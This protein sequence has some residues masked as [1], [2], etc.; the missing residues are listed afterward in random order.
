LLKKLS[1]LILSSIVIFSYCSA[2]SAKTTFTNVAKA[3][4]LR[5]VRRSSS[6]APVWGDYDNDG[7][8]DIYVAH[9]N[10]AGWTMEG[11]VFFRNNGD[12]T[13]TDVTEEAGLDKNTGDNDHAG[14]LDY[15]NDGNLDLY[16]YNSTDV[17]DRIA[18][19][20]N[21]GD[22]TFTDVTEEA[23][24]G[25]EPGH[26]WSATFSDYNNDGHLDIYVTRVWNNPNIFFESNGDGTFTDQTD[27]AGIG[28]SSSCVNVISG[29]Y[30]NDG[31]MDIYLA[32]GGGNFTA[33]ATFYRNNGDGTFTD[34]TEKAGVDCDKGGRCTAFFDY[35]NDGDLDIYAGGG[36]PIRL[37]RNNGD[38]TFTDVAKEAGVL[39]IPAFERLTVGDYD[40]D[41]YMDIFVMPW[42]KSRILYHNNGDGTFTDVAKETGVQP[43]Q[44]RVGGCAFADYD[45]DG[46]LDLYI[47]N[48]GGYDALYR[49][50]GN[51][52]H[53]LHIKCTG[54]IGDIPV[55]V[56]RTNKDGVGARVIIQA[57][58]LSMIRE[59]NPGCSRGYN[60]LIAYFG[61]GQNTTADSLEIRWPSGQVTTLANVPAD[62]MIEVKEGVEGYKKIEV[63]PVK[64]IAVEPQGKLV[65]TW[66]KVKKNKLY[67]NYPNPFNPETWIPYQLAKSAN[68]AIRIY[69]QSGQ[70][71]RTLKLGHK[72]EGIYQE[73]SQAAHWDGRN[74]VDEPVASG[75]YFYR[76]EAGDFC[77][78]R[79]MTVVK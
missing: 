3:A 48:L 79:K 2:V 42:N 55:N 10:W 17:D 37:Y 75:V 43:A 70:L 72:K 47:A 25:L 35:D 20:H 19:Y 76:F 64:Q 32:N 36:R 27:R 29:D 39:L 67:Q 56:K 40:N 23:G 73:K 14:F 53:W 6:M 13:F 60:P 33:P 44:G 5:E 30:D 78:I 77:Q 59:I 16:V 54:S 8:L 66:A 71:V 31:D 52:N 62:Q 21:N 61:L 51:D 4:G 24:T 58:Q 57:G 63:E 7:D 26:Y 34:V 22:G 74:D 11:D 15:D 45:N 28:D 46:D 65:T 18:L 12:G 69:T 9:G 38:G 1:L 68:V 49:N 50:E 41:G